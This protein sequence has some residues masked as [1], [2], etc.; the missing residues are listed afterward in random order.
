MKLLILVLSALYGAVALSDPIVIA[1]RGASG[2]LPEHT[3]E[4]AALA[5][6]LG[7]NYIEQDLVLSRDG[8]PVVLHDIH[9]DTVTNV[10]ALFPKRKRSDG[11]YYAIDF[12][13]KELKTLTVH[14]R[15]D[16]NGH[17]VFPNRYQGSA[18]FGIATFAEH[19][20]LIGNLNRQFQRNVGLY[21]EIKAPAWHLKQGFDIS[22]IVIDV[23]REHG[24]DTPS[25]RVYIQCFDFNEIKRIATELKPNVPLIQLIGYRSADTDYD[26][27][28]S[29]TGIHEMQKYVQGVGPAIS[30]LVNLKKGLAPTDFALT[31]RGSPLEIHPYTH[32]VDQLPNGTSSEALL[33]ALFEA[34]ATGVFTDFPDRVHRSAK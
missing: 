15:R 24:L 25:S 30:Q 17:Q 6:N 10:A 4:A 5:F 32:R 11:R 16:R 18:Q 2:Y 34:G 22:Q 20:E 21:P 31:L 33:N 23:L 13:L 7:S 9:L 29:K 14:E 1:H 28:R 27:L 26:Y 3:L 12:D 19:I 8:V